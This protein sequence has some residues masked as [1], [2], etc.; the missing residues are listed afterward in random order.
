MFEAGACATSI[1]EVFATGDVSRVADLVAADYRD[2]QGRDGTE[3]RRREGFELVV[4]AAR[5]FRR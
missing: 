3:I 2:H 1:V 4:A 5:R